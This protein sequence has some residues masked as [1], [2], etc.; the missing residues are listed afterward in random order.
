[1]SN[2]SSGM[3]S[4]QVRGMG[5]KPFETETHSSRFASPDGSSCVSLRSV[6][7]VVFLATSLLAREDLM[8]QQERVD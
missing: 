4:W 1:M 3:E 6:D 2:L 8:L 7:H 5:G